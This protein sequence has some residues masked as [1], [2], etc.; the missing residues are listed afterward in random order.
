MEN[1]AFYIEKTR[2]LDNSYVKEKMEQWEN[3]IPY[4]V[5]MIERHI[6]IGYD[7]V[8]RKKKRK[9]EMEDQADDSDEKAQEDNVLEQNHGEP[10]SMSLGVENTQLPMAPRKSCRRSISNS[11]SL[12]TGTRQPNLYAKPKTPT[13]PIE[14][15]SP[16][17]SSGTRDICGTISQGVF[18][19]KIPPTSSK[20]SKLERSSRYGIV[21]DCDIN[22]IND[23]VS[24]EANT[25][26]MNMFALW[27]EHIFSSDI[28]EH[29]WFVDSLWFSY[30]LTNTSQLAV[31]NFFGKV[32]LAAQ[33]FTFFPIISRSHW[34]LMVFYN[35]HLR[36]L[37]G[38]PF[39]Q[40]SLLFFDSLSMCSII[41]YLP[42]IE[43]ALAHFSNYCS[44]EVIKE[45]LLKPRQYCHIDS[46][47]PNGFDCGYYVMTIM[48]FL[49]MGGIQ[50]KRS[51]QWL[52]KKM[53]KHEDVEETKK[54]LHSW[55]QKLLV[56]H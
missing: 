38:L 3:G 25:Q 53:I 19:W 12:I 31:E 20:A 4:R 9:K 46:I 45:E 32:D 10:T 40:S 51:R 52:S 26:S 22:L 43:R 21:A 27:M 15:N 44:H 24:S 50:H 2:E 18:D 37:S 56:D 7:D 55:T 17:G 39:G 1:G 34:T 16:I 30:M 5:Q 35:G 42:H 48:R 13:T 47:E 49:I 11:L 23:I 41:D 36:R 6:K 29:V 8:R 14:I 33:T 54:I 28:I